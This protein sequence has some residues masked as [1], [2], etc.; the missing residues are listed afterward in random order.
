MSIFFN[1][2][3]RTGNNLYQYFITRILADM[4]RLNITSNFRSPVLNFTIHNS[5]TQLCNEQIYVNDSNIYDII[6]YKNEYKSKNMIV[7]GFFQDSLFFNTN[8]NKIIKYL[9]LPDITQNYDDIVLHIR[10]NDFNRDGNKS[11]VIHPNWYLNILENETFNKLYIV[12]DLGG[13]KKYRKKDAEQNYLN[14]FSK[15]NP[16][17]IMNK[18]YD[19][20]HFI[21]SFDKI[22]CSNSTFSW[23]A[24]FLSNA[25]RIYTPSKW[26][27]KKKLQNILHKTITFDND[28]CDINILPKYSYQID[29]INQSNNK[30]DNCVVIV[31]N[32]NYFEKAINTIKNIRTIGAYHDDLVFIYGKDID[33]SDLE[34]LQDFYVIP[35]YF[36]DLDLSNVIHK[37]KNKPYKGLE[38]KLYKMF[39]F[40]KFHLFN[41]YFKRWKTIFYIDCGMRIFKPIKPFFELDCRNKILANSDAQPKYRWKLGIQFNN[42][43]YSDVY[44]QLSNEF[45]LNIDYF[46][47]TI[48]IYDTSIIKSDTFDILRELLYKYPIGK[49]NDQAIMNLHFNC[50]LNIWKQVPLKHNK[51]LMYDYKTRRGCRHT[52]YIMLK[53]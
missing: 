45:N 31:S 4:Y 33:K 5:Y 13:W 52:D 3:G 34:R 17:I 11:N 36:P 24:A 46:Q 15:Y 28:S 8:Y 35:K 16:V 37:L 39:C 40:H 26:R 53:I 20:F 21:R 7:E 30:M 27:G 6:Q 18:E 43:S 2:K 47:S 51:Q 32:K 50:Q 1:K 12:V 10:L 44:K 22:I 25:S 9:D 49:T 14:Y 29:N 23:W 41:T 38:R 48:L 42:D 19:D